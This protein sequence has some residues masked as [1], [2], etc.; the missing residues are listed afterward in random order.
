MDSEGYNI[1]FKVNPSY[2]EIV[3]LLCSGMIGIHTMEYEHFG[4]AVV[5]MMVE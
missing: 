4:I 2:S 3:K 5:E 1:E